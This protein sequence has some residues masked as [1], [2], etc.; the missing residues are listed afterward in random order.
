MPKVYT[1]KAGKDYPEFGIR[2]GQTYYAWSFYRQKER[3]SLVRPK[4]SQLTQV[5][6]ECLMLEAYE[7]DA[8]NCPED[9]EDMIQILEQ[10]LGEAE[11][12]NENLSEHFD[13]TERQVMAENN[14]NELQNAIDE[15]TE[16]IEAW[17]EEPEND[18]DYGDEA[19]STEPEWEK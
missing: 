18:R 3:K 5:A 8:P 11:T 16:I 2:K 7:R 9:I 6:G 15:L 4:P 10:A 14:V 19:M 12:T 1:R 17:K 13:G